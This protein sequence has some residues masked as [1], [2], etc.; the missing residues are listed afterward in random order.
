MS[1]RLSELR[2][3]LKEI[4]KE[5]Q[6]LEWIDEQKLEKLADNFENKYIWKDF[7]TPNYKQYDFCYIK[8]IKDINNNN[9]IRCNG[10]R[11]SQRID[12]VNTSYSI[13]KGDFFFS[14]F[15]NWNFTSKEK[16]KTICA[17]CITNL[18]SI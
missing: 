16:F 10:I 1:N 17:E 3:Q 18:T 9:W 6:I 14:N 2:T 4:Q 13:S 15:L 11:I 12:S 7:S 8:S 5:I